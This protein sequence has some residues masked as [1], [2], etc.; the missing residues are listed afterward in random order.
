MLNFCKDIFDEYL[1]V[2]TCKA[3]KINKLFSY[4][5]DPVILKKINAYDSNS[6]DSEINESNS[7]TNKSDSNIYFKFN[8]FD[9]NNE[10][11]YKLHEK[12]Q[13]CMKK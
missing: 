2:M 3:K 7:D 6:D 13:L 4:E 10:Y 9:S 8:N 11:N 1:Q 5:Y 12:L